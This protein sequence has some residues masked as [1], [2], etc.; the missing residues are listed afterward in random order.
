MTYPFKVLLGQDDVVGTWVHT[1]L[2]GSWIPCQGNSIGL[3]D[4][5]GKIVVGWTYSA[6]NGV[7]C[8]V[9]VVAEA[10]GWCTPEFLYMAFS[11]PFEQLGCKRITSPIAWDNIHCLDFVK[12]LGATHEATLEGAGKTGDVHIYKMFKEDCRWLD[13]PAVMPEIILG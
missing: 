5:S 1:R 11:Y 6:Y 8:V 10:K 12:W 2:N 4:A 7:N 13:K 3:V 9:D